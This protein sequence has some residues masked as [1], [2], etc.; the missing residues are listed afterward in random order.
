MAHFAAKKTLFVT[1]KFDVQT[2][3]QSAVALLVLS[4]PPYTDDPYTSHLRSP[5]IP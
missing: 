2:R 3:S 1:N 5:A 4:C